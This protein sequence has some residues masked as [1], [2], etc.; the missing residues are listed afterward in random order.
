MKDQFKQELLIVF[1]I[2]IHRFL[3]IDMVRKADVIPDPEH[4]WVPVT[5][6]GPTVINVC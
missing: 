1:F 5:N 4:N 2:K 6:T 3:K